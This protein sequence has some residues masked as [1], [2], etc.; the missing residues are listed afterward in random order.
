MTSGWH[1][2]VKVSKSGTLFFIDR[3]LIMESFMLCFLLLCLGCVSSRVDDREEDMDIDTFM[4][5]T[6]LLVWVQGS[7][8]LGEEEASGQLDSVDNWE[9]FWSWKAMFSGGLT[10]LCCC[11]QKENFIIYIVLGR[12]FSY[13]RIIHKKQILVISLL[14][15]PRKSLDIFF[16]VRLRLHALHVAPWYIE[17]SL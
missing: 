5:D 8:F 12:V 16:L 10:S 17:R 9:E 11:K 1:V 6:D 4:L 3:K 15:D 7:S 13:Y 2:V 14:R